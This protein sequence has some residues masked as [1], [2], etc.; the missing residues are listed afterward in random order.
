MNDSLTRNIADVAV[1]C[2][3][4][5]RPEVAHR[6]GKAVAEVFAERGLP[7]AGRVRFTAAPCSGG[8]VLV[9][10]DSDAAG[11]PVRVQ[12]TGRAEEVVDRTVAR[13]ARSLD[14]LGAPSWQPRPWP[15][16][17]RPL[18]AAV[19]DGDVVRRKAAGARSC[20]P[21]AAAAA[22]DALDYDAYLF[23]DADTGEDA[24]VFRAGPNGVRLAR[25]HCL[26]PPSTA[27]AITVHPHPTPTLNE[28][29]AVRRLCD[30]GLPF[31]FYSDAVTGRGRLLYRR[32]DG[33]LGLVLPEGEDTTTSRRPVI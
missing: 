29:A 15:D 21:V 12:L 25:R 13:L 2:R 5:V 11:S 8:P 9:Q 22:L 31:L 32:Y 26:H 3:G 30:H 28:L 14:G 1:V 4:A 23:V 33:D 18:L 7:T 24:V 10:V 17:A 27:S 19:L 20:E 16:S 6:L